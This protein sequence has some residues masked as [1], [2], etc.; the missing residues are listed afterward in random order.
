MLGSGFEAEDVVQETL[1][2]AWRCP[3]RFDE[4]RGPLLPWLH[5]IKHF[6]IQSLHMSLRGLSF[7]R[8]NRRPTR[9][10]ST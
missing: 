10:C 6:P 8:G 1:I 4:G 3:S 9:M 2:R 5:A 7:R